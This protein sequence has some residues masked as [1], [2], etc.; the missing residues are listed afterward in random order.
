MAALLLDTHAL[1]WY[2][3]QRSISVDALLAIAEAQAESQL[4]VSTI[5][6]WELGVAQLKAD[7]AKRPDLSGLPAVIWFDRALKG[8][9]AKA[10]QLDWD[11]VME[12]TAVPPVYGS[13]DPG[14]CFLIA[15]ARK[16]KMA[17]VTRDR[18]ILKL[19]AQLPQYLRTV[20]C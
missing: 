6:A 7:P 5:S 1:L 4:F 3:S 9:G 12:A 15:T 20:V 18:N 14:D 19:S 16:R 2:D 11:I 13:G 17:L 10:L 8:I